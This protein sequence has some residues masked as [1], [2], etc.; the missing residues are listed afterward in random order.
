MLCP[1]AWSSCLLL[2]EDSG[3]EEFFMSAVCL[4]FARVPVVRVERGSSSVEYI[5]MYCK[6]QSWE[7]VFFAVLSEA[8]LNIKTYIFYKYL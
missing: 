8:G 6:K 4:S 1:D 5:H 2:R 7:S 3:G